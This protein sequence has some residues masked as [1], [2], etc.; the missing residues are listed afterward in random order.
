MQ[1]VVV[2]VLAVAVAV[3][4]A[5]VAVSRAHFSPK[6]S[7]SLIYV[8]QRGSCA[9]PRIFYNIF[10]ATCCSPIPIAVAIP[11]PAP[12]PMPVQHV[13]VVEKSALF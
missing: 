3:V 1:R 9:T 7:L 4:V 13:Q 11:V 12:V 10:A 6:H 8:S 5:V 2:I